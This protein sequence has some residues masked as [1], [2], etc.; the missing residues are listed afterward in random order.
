MFKC[1]I[2]HFGSLYISF[3]KP[4]RTRENQVDSLSRWYLTTTGSA[5]CEDMRYN[6]MRKH[7]LTE[8]AEL[9]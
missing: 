8:R 7:P 3:L 2:P 4:K 9:T 1:V 6:L 5:A